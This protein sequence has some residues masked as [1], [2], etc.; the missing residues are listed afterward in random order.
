EAGAKFRAEID[1]HEK[2]LLS[3]NDAATT[4]ARSLAEAVDGLAGKLAAAAEQVGERFGKRIGLEQE[5][6][7]RLSEA[8]D[9]R[10]LTL[11]QEST[12]Q[13]ERLTLAMEDLMARLAQ[14]VA[15]LSGEVDRQGSRLGEQA[16]A[17]SD[18]LKER[19]EQQVRALGEVSA[20]IGRR[21]DEIDQLLR[22]EAER[23]D[24]TTTSTGE[25]FRAIFADESLRLGERAT[26]SAALLKERIEAEIAAL[27]DLAR[28]V[29]ERADETDQMIRSGGERIAAATSAAQ[30]GFRNAFTSETEKLDRHA[31][32]AADQ[33]KE[34]IEQQ[35]AALEALVARI[36]ERSNETDRLIEGGGERISAAVDSAQSALRE[37]F[38]AEREK[39]DQRATGAADLLKQR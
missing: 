30:E 21:A 25:R 16:N 39:L 27:N 20:G 12:A 23:L 35:I 2:R 14:R 15:E 17:A 34:R 9:R 28:H 38:S 31:A 33:L 6:L 4:Q 36:G 37:M 8:A 13:G 7:N 26:A 5:S 18:R 29:G 19:I 3:I 24:A 1:L 11:Q 10:A 32:A 22:S